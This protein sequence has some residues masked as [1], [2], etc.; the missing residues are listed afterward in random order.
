MKQHIWKDNASC[1][2][3]DTNLFFEKYEDEVETR[4]QID[5]ICRGCP[6][7][8]QCFAVGISGKEYGVWGGIFIENGSIS[9]EFN[10]HKSKSDWAESWKSLTMGGN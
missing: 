2:G 1:L 6:V 10:K 3:L 5:A 4:P 8:R 9:R 7:V